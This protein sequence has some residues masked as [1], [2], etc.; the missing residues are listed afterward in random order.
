MW[1]LSESCAWLTGQ[2]DVRASWPLF[3]P[4]P[5]PVDGRQGESSSQPHGQAAPPKAADQTGQEIRG[6][7]NFPFL[8]QEIRGLTD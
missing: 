1:C 8:L 3:P 5:A 4:F 6:N 7:D 2:S